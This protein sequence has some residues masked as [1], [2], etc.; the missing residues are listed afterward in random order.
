MVVVETIVAST[1][2]TWIMSNWL[3]AQQRKLEKAKK[4]E[5]ETKSPSLASSEDD[6]SQP[7]SRDE[8]RHESIPTEIAVN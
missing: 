3:N 2:S 4:A 6:G 7:A 1:L 5:H 8:K